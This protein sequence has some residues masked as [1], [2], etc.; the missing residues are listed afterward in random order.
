M[1]HLQQQQPLP[2]YETI[3]PHP[4]DGTRLE[5][6]E[7]G[8]NGYHVLSREQRVNPETNTT[9]RRMETIPKDSREE[10]YGKLELREES[11]TTKKANEEEYS[12]LE[13]MN[14]GSNLPKDTN[15]DNDATVVSN[16]DSSE[17]TEGKRSVTDKKAFN[18]DGDIL[19]LESGDVEKNGKEE[20]TKG[21]QPLIT[22]TPDAQNNR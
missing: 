3:P 7:Q 14:I 20:E 13:T 5:F 4:R 6:I 10:S 11:S 16:D 12:K 22:I 1:L 18:D 2:A 17:Q 15:L 19:Q 8:D 9:S 21:E